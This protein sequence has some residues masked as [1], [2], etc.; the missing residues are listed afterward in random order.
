ML[1]AFDP[2]QRATMEAA[3]AVPVKEGRDMST[4]AADLRE[5]ENGRGPGTATRG[6]PETS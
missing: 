1:G 2:G 5:L 3:S 4:V 6:L